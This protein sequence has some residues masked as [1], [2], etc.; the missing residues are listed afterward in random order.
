ML[1]IAKENPCIIA[2]R[3]ACEVLKKKVPV[4]QTFIYADME[5]RMKRVVE[6]YGESTE[7]L[8]SIS[9]R[10]IKS[11]KCIISITKKRQFYGR[12]ILTCVLTTINC[13]STGLF[14]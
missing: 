7:M 4:L 13:E 12:N 5:A 8:K 2:G 1:N 10:S 11:V 14:S 6:Q 3:G 9:G